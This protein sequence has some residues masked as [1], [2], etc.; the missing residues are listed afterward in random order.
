MNKKDPAQRH[1]HEKPLGRKLTLAELPVLKVATDNAGIM[2]PVP[3][4]G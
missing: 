4:L 1:V 2:S 3:R